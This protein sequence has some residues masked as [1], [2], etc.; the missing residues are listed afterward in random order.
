M[1]FLNISKYENS[2]NIKKACAYAYQEDVWEYIDSEKDLF[3]EIMNDY[4]RTQIQPET[5]IKI[6]SSKLSF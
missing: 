4:S 6:K 5:N 1:H 3:D 2:K